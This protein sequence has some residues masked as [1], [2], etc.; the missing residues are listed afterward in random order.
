MK[1]I[2]DELVTTAGSPD[3]CFFLHSSLA[4][5]LCRA[6][7]KELKG[8]NYINTVIR[9]NIEYLRHMA[10]SG[11]DNQEFNR[12]LSNFIFGKLKL[13]EETDEETKIKIGFLQSPYVFTE[14]KD[15]LAQL[16]PNLIAM[17]LQILEGQEAFFDYFGVLKE[18]I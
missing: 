6:A 2:L 5:L 8:E 1:K 12:F 13:G 17:M 16:F 15:R 14:V 10:E 18:K 11:V 7:V 9:Y 4:E 3:R